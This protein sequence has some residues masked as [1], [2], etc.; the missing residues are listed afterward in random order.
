MQTI[1]IDLGPSSYA[2][3]VGVGHEL[4][5]D[6]S[7][8]FSGRLL[9]VTSPQVLRHC[10]RRLRQAAPIFADAA[11][12]KTPDGESH[13]TLSSVSRLYRQLLKKG[14]D[15]KTTLA[16]LGGGV[17]GD[18]A[19]FVAAT[20]LRGIPYLQVPTTLVAQIDSSIGGKVGVN[21]KEG[22]NLVG[23]F[24]QPQAVFA[25]VSFLST[26]PPREF[27]SGLGEAFKC[28]LVGDPQLY[29]L[30]NRHGR[31]LLKDSN[32]LEE[33]VGRAIRVK[34]TI[35]S[36]DEREVTGVRRQLNLGHTL[37]HALEQMTHYR[38][39]R[40][41]EAVA[42]GL[43]LAAKASWRRGL[44]EASVASEIQDNLKALGF[45]TSPPDFPKERWRVAIEVDKKREEGM[46][47]FVFIK[48]IGEVVVEPIS[49]KELL[50]L[51]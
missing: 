13:K 48:A 21:L 5:K 15:R 27:L 22:K 11:V 34:A 8:L 49:V 9:L 44:C 16:I 12:I 43:A 37:G 20:C 6:V 51:L 41:G 35:I 47:H 2:V 14:A 30:L 40:H 31:S 36:Q 33:M 18:L 19:G 23:A 1:P 32:L 4:F 24:Y 25:D 45:Q 42:I 39:F 10:L 17:V 7:T 28:S 38:R 46:I 26:L 3:R 29:H 50:S